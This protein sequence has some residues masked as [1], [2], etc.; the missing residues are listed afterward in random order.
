[1]SL[2]FKPMQMREVLQQAL[3]L[4]ASDV[5]IVVGSP[6]NI[7]IHGVLQPLA[8]SPILDAPGAQDLIWQVLTPQQ[9]NKLTTNRELDFSLVVAGI[10]RYRAN[11]YF[12][13]GIP[14]LSLRSISDKIP[15]IDQLRLPQI[16]HTFAS[17]KQGFV[18]V[19][20]PTGQ[21]KS[22]TLAAIIE[23]I[24]VSRSEHIVTIEDPIEF[25]YTPQKSVISQR[26]LGGDTMSWGAAL[27]SVLREDPNVVLV[28][29]MRDPETMAAAIT[30]AE[31]GHL[32]FATLH[33]NSAAQT[34]DRIIDSFPEE[35]QGQ[36]KVQLSNSL[37][38]VFSQ[39]LVPAI[40]GGRI[41]AAEVLLATPAVRNMI[42][43]GKTYQIDSV[44]QTSSDVGMMSFEASLASWVNQGTVEMSKALEFSLKPADL[45]RLTGRP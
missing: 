41:A 11:A 14:G 13:K 4:A 17:L 27:K 2:R 7:R 8:N 24:N 1:M 26:E 15:T 10:S 31:T 40:Q 29:E 34:I 18:L 32:V 16:C 35:Q 21:G 19:T 6:I 3:M 20:G 38:A 43:E 23:E 37:E 39:R 28:G 12:T 44:I 36:I 45:K 25:V 9:Q 5:H 30:V 42:R 33:T 22:S